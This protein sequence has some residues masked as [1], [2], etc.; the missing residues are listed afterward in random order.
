MFIIQRSVIF[1]VEIVIKPGG[2][3]MQREITSK[4]ARTVIE[5]TTRYTCGSTILI[6]T[7]PRKD[8][9]TSTI[10]ASC[11]K[12]AKKGFAQAKND[13]PNPLS[14]AISFVLVLTK[15]MRY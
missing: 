3:I 6:R 11:A 8:I 5:S 4:T 9:D 14:Q 10:W 2:Q 15:H 12:H 1:G 7:K 13:D